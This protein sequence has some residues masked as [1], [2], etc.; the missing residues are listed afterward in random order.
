M[1]QQIY[2]WKY[3][4]CCKSATLRLSLLPSMCDLHVA[5]RSLD[6]STGVRL[7]QKSEHTMT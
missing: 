2:S 7:L 6:K 5:K 1:P 4:L 3:F